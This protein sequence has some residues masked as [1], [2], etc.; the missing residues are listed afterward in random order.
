MEQ[1]PLELEPLWVGRLDTGSWTTIETARAAAAELRQLGLGRATIAVEHSFIPDDA[2]ATLERELPG[3]TFVEALPLLAELRAIKRPDELAELREAADEIVSSMVEVIGS[4]E[5]GVT[6]R[7]LA[8]RVRVAETRRGLSSEYCLTAAGPSTLRAP[9]DAAWMGGRALSLD[10]GASLNGYVGDL[11]RMGCMGEPSVRMEE[12]LAQVDAV[13]QAARGRVRAGAT[14]AEVYEAALAR[15]AECPDGA[16]MSFVAHGMGLIPHEVPY[17]TDTR[18]VPYPA[19]HR[20][21]PFEPGMVL[22]I[23]T[24]LSDPEVGFVKLEDTVAVTD[25]GADAFGDRGRGWNVAPLA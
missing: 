1:R 15:Q 8:E 4:A 6:T 16:N 17:L 7:T 2:R 13:Q 9:T 14:G 12:L 20:H 11:A 18:T 23:E 19:I 10:S 21:R 5:E 3:A 24:D 22:S 25:T